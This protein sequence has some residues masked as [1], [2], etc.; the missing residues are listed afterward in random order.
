[1]TEAT[2]KGAA[3][4]DRYLAT[5]EKVLQFKS[6]LRGAEAAAECAEK[7]LAKWLAPDDIQPGEKIAVWHTDSLYQVESLHGSGTLEVTIRT[8]GKEGQ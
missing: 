5:K 1:M 3:L 7:E 6:S 4:I 2:Q 8:R